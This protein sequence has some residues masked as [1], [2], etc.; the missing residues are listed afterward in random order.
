MTTK[1]IQAKRPLTKK[2][3]ERL[4]LRAARIQIAMQTGLKYETVAAYHRRFRREVGG[5]R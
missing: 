2:Q 5:Q 3:Q 1:S 4:A